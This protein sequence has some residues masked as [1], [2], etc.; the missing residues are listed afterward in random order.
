MKDFQNI[1]KNVGQNARDIVHEADKTVETIKAINEKHE[2]RNQQKILE[3]LDMLDKLESRNKN[4]KWK[5]WLIIGVGILFLGLLGKCSCGSGDEAA[6]QKPTTYVEA[7]SQNDYQTAHEIL[8]RLLQKAI[9]A[10]AA[11]SWS[12][13][14]YLEDFW[15]AADHVYKSEMMYLIEMN[16][17]EANKRLIYTLAAMNTIGYK[18]TGAVLKDFDVNLKAK[19]YAI[20]VTRYNRL[21]DEILNI[22]ILNNNSEM[23]KAVLGLYK[24]DC[25][26]L[27]DKETK[28]GYTYHYD[29][30]SRSKP[31]AQ[32]K[33]NAAVANGQLK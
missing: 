10:N 13:E 32:K 33:Y 11:G 6:S 24:D 18:P 17:P 2:Q 21:C 7:V 16:D 8:D 26:F 1:I 29:L 30:T 4:P 23:A 9:D 20:F 25:V 22:S 28:D 12:A 27:Y 15:G 3:H 19:N 14:D 5:K 31:A